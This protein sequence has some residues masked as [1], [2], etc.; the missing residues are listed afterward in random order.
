MSDNPT[1]GVVDANEISHKFSLVKW[2]Y[3]FLVQT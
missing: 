1:I 2:V 3:W